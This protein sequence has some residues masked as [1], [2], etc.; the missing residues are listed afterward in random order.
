MNEMQKHVLLTLGALWTACRHMLQVCR[1]FSCFRMFVVCS[2]VQAFTP[3][4]VFAQTMVTESS[5][6]FW[7]I[8][9]NCGSPI[10]I[11]AGVGATFGS[12][13]CRFGNCY[14]S[15]AAK[16]LIRYVLY[17]GC[18]SNMHTVGVHPNVGSEI[19]VAVSPL[20]SEARR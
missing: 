2:Q 8:C 16:S 1:F 3:I 17:S 14:S 7:D 6:I 4:S 18:V 9:A 20:L 13:I 15:T 12:H 5:Q 10:H 19:S 11:Y